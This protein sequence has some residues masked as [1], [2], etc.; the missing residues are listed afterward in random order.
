MLGARS[1]EGAD[2]WGPWA[3]A[4]RAEGAWREAGLEAA[5]A[6]MVAGVGSVRETVDGPP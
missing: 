4:S 2:E 5:A 6:L 1:G 3:P